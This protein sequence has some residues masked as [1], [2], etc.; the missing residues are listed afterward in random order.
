MCSYIKTIKIYEIFIKKKYL[1]L[2]NRQVPKFPKLD[3]TFHKNFTYL[4]LC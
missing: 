1:I 4:H 2:I 3:S